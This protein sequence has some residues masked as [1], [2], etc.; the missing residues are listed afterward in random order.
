MR[1]ATGGFLVASL[2]MVPAERHPTQSQTPSVFRATADSVVIDVA[3]TRG[4]NAVTGLSA[5]DFRVFDNGVPQTV[6]VFS[7][8][9]IPVDVSLLLEVTSI[10]PRRLLDLMTR[11]RSITESL[12]PDDRFRLW[13]I[14]TYVREI[15]PMQE[16]RAA[17]LPE[18]VP[19]D[20]LTASIYDALGLAMTHRV[21]PG[22]RHLVLALAREYD[23]RSAVPPATLLEMA[24]RADAVVNIIE[25]GVD[26]ASSGRALETRFRA[27]DN[28]RGT[29]QEVAERTGGEF[30]GQRVF[31]DRILDAASRVLNG[32]RQ[33]YVLQ[34]TR[35]GVALPG[36]H[37]VRVELPN[38]RGVS[39]RARKGY[40]GG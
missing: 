25:I 12:R 26:S 17:V 14:G 36:W 23:L 39:V 29:L 16:A 5:S 10:T 27:D 21:E 28:G 15:S 19:L 7:I 22:R 37:E 31:G 32:F 33:S 3:V 6:S 40:S 13:S 35:V 38:I 2:L 9:A 34:Y 8:S 24:R 1:S 30:T 4:G 20:G 18:H 11:I